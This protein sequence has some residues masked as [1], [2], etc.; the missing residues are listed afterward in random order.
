MRTD[1][2]RAIHLS[3]YR[4]P[5]YRISEVALDFTL[6]P[7]ATRVASRMR[8]TRTGAAGAPLVLNGEA[9]KLVSVAIDGHPLEADQ[10]TVDAELLTIAELP[11]KFV[12]EIVTEIAPAENTLLSGLYTSKGLFCTQ[13]EA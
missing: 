2:P 10:Y 3:E 6:D 7:Q 5:D 13:C 9:V 4:T 8:M 11:E 12:L 1:E